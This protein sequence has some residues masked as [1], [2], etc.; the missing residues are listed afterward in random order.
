MPLHLAGAGKAHA[1][2]APLELLGLPEKRIDVADER[3]RRE[4]RVHRSAA[5]VMAIEH[6]PAERAQPHLDLRVG[7]EG[8]DDPPRLLDADA[9]VVLAVIEGA[10]ATDQ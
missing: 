9:R 7:D 8:I 3:D 2:S 10:A 4:Q 1:P 6:E 5:S